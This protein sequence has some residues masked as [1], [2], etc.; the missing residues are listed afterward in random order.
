MDDRT[1]R[2]KGKLITQLG[3]MSVT[4]PANTT[5]VIK[6]DSN[7]GCPGKPISGSIGCMFMDSLY[8]TR[9]ET[10]SSSSS[11]AQTS[12]KKVYWKKISTAGATYAAINLSKEKE[13]LILLISDNGKGCDI[14]KEKNGVGL[15]NIRSRVQLYDETVTIVSKPGEGYQLKVMLPLSSLI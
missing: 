7:N 14:S 4:P 3:H 11:F 10:S 9:M 12:P 15:I 13:E 5:G 2:S 6:I 8:W 1:S